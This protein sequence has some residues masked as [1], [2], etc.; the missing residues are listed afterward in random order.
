MNWQFTNKEA[1]IKLSRL[2]PTLDP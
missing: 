1:R 2:Y